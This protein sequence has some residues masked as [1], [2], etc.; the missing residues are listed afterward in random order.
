MIGGFQR[1]LDAV[2]VTASLTDV[3]SGELVRTAR[4]DGS[5]H[6]IFE[7]QDRLVRELASSLR[8]AI[9]PAST[10]RRPKWSAPTRRSRAG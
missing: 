8:A 1:S 4:V 3:A 10:G 2:R 5:V 7:L 9:A 6:A